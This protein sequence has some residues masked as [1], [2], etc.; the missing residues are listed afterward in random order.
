MAEPKQTITA[1]SFL[2]AIQQAEEYFE[3]PGVGTVKIRSMSARDAQEIYQKYGNDRPALVVAVVGAG[4]TEPVLTAEQ[5]GIL[6]TSKAG[7]VMELFER[8]S[9]I[10]GMSS[11]TEAEAL[12]DLAGGGSSS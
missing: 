9:V 1:E 8:I 12:S 11:G 5:I 4:L 3:L 2:R 7:P 10:S 6:Y